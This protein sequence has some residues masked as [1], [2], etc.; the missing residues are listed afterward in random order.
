MTSKIKIATCKL[1]NPG[2]V[3]VLRLSTVLKH[4]IGATRPLP[5]DGGVEDSTKTWWCDPTSH[6]LNVVVQSLPLLREVGRMR[7]G[8]RPSDHLQSYGFH[9]KIRLVGPARLFSVDESMMHMT[10][11]Y[12][13]IM[14]KK[15]TKTEIVVVISRIPVLIKDR[16]HYFSMQVVMNKCFLLIP[17]K[18]FGANPSCRFRD[19]RTFNSEK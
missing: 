19:K 12:P 8:V 13:I 17:E 2:Y 7:D 5:R 9:K 6:R 10:S 4:K 18:K 11:Q 15:K 16:M 1:Q 3:T 14:L